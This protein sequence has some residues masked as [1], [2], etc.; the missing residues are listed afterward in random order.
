[1]GEGEV[2]GA[3]ALAVSVV[4]IRLLLVVSM[5]LFGTCMQVTVDLVF[6]LV[7]PVTLVLMVAWEHAGVVL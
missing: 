2:D 3:G 4:L 5:I 7:M 6:V 1:M